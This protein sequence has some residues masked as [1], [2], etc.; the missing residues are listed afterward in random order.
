MTIST[1]YDT[2]ALAQ[3]QQM[4]SGMHSQTQASGLQ[5]QQGG[6]PQIAAAPKN[7]NAAQGAQNIM[8]M[9]GGLMGGSGASGGMNSL[10]QGLGFAMAP[11]G[12]EG[13]F[14]ASSSVP[15]AISSLASMLG[16]MF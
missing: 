8:G 3:L 5:Q 15:S 9:I 12:A 11:A 1:Q 2:P 4:L 14:N 16:G 10:G 6:I 13:P 7:P